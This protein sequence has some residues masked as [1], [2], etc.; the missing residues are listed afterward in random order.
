MRALSLVATDRQR[1][2]VDHRLDDIGRC[3]IT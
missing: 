3:S 2:R 1:E